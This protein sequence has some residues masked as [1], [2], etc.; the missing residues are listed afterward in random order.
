ME[1]D[2]DQNIVLISFFLRYLSSKSQSAQRP[3][4]FPVIENSASII[5]FVKTFL[6]RY[7]TLEKLQYGRGFSSE[8]LS[9]SNV[10]ASRL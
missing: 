8:T 2:N 1:I 5:I 9:Y 7:C 6:H 3:R 4:K 10:D